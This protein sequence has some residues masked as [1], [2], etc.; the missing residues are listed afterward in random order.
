MLH[1]PHN[2]GARIRFKIVWNIY[3]MIEDAEMIRDLFEDVEQRRKEKGEL[4]LE[5]CT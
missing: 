1:G 2:V 5:T 4:F 3:F